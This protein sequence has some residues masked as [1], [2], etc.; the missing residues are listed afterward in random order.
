[1]F[2]SYE[3]FY[4]LKG[5]Y[6]LFTNEFSKGGGESVSYQVPTQQAL[7]G[8]TDAL[9]FKPTIR[10]VVKEVKVIN[11][12]Q[13]E[14][15]GV[16]ALVKGGADLNYVTYLKDVEY[17][18]RYHFEWNE[19]RPDLEK[20]RN[21]GKHQAIAER[22]LKR[23]GRRDVFLGTRECMADADWISQEEYEDTESYYHNQ[24]ISLG[25]MFHS[26]RYPSESGG[27]LKAYYAD[28]QMTDG[29][30]QFKS[31]EECEIEREITNYHFQINEQIKS[32]DDE[33]MEY[34]E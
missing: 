31:Q 14:T 23:G 2:K 9:Y 33:Y 24:T 19:D 6:A 20:D 32:V 21:P 11:P 28:T 8:I 22:S 3:M 16:R 7:T 12:I 4:R 26:F 27:M 1:M 13:T 15:K 34:F 17:L 5:E 30:I 10:N 18:V 29:I 25:I